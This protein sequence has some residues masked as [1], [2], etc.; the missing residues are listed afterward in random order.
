M[1]YVTSL[2]PLCLAASLG[3]L[4]GFLLRILVTILIT[5]WLS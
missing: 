4:A 1:R 3:I 5:Q 2:L